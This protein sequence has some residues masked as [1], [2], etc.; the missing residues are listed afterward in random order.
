[1]S[2]PPRER[3]LVFASEYVAAEDEQEAAEQMR[4]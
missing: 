3:S 4:R 2:L 1:M